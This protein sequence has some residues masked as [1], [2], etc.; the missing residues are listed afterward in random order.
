MRCTK[1]RSVA[2]NLD[3]GVCQSCYNWG[4]DVH[5]RTFLVMGPGGGSWGWDRVVGHGDR[6]GRAETIVPSDGSEG[7]PELLNGPVQ[8]SQKFVSRVLRTSV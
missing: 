7:V 2:I 3:V 6:S 5:V 4:T 8:I 1:Q